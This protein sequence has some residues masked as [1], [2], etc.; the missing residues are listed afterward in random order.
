[1][2]IWW[3]LMFHLYFQGFCSIFIKDVDTCLKYAYSPSPSFSM[4]VI[5]IWQQDRSQPHLSYLA[6]CQASFE[7]H[8]VKEKNYFENSNRNGLT[9][10]ITWGGGGEE[11]KK[12]QI[13]SLVSWKMNKKIK[14]RI[15]YL[16]F[17]LFRRKVAICRTKKFIFYRIK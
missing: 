5:S 7:F 12:G 3:K 17:L 10:F 2:Y 4:L 16:K 11:Y 8:T 14:F 1:M 9:L 6:W 15:F 13:L